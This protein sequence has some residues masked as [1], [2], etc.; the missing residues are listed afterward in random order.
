MI[1]YYR[2]I[3]TVALSCIVSRIQP[4]IGRKSRN[5]YTPPLFNAS[6][7][8]G[9]PRRNFERCLV[10]E[11]LECWGYHMLKKVWRYVKPFRYNIAAWQTEE[12][13]DGR[14]DGRNSF[15]INALL[16]WRAIKIGGR[17]HFVSSIPTS[18]T[19]C[20]SSGAVVGI[21]TSLRRKSDVKYANA[22]P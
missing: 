14:T 18:T 2:S 11:T 6:M 9:W 20:R 5:L 15:I 4:D 13:T 12:R 16:C 10:L 22:L 8:K 19:V 17:R 7:D 21:N 3:L 1:S